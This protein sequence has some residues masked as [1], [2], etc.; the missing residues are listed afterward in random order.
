VERAAMTDIIGLTFISNNNVFA[1]DALSLGR[2]VNIQS[3]PIGAFSTPI[4]VGRFGDPDF[5][6]YVMSQDGTIRRF[7]GSSFTATSLGPV[8]A[9]FNVGQETQD[10][11][12]HAHDTL[13]VGTGTIS[14]GSGS[15]FALDDSSGNV[16]W[17]ISGLGSVP[18][19]AS[20][21]YSGNTPSRVI[22]CAAP[23]ILALEAASGLPVWSFFGSGQGQIVHGQVVY[24]ANY[25]DSSLCA[26]SVA[27][28]SL[29][30][31]YVNPVVGANFNTPATH[32]SVVYATSVA[33]TAVALDALTGNVIWQTNVPNNP[34]VPVVYPADQ[35][36]V[37]FE[38]GKYSA[39]SSFLH[40]LDASS[41]SA[42]WTSAIPVAGPGLG[43]TD[44]IWT[45]NN[46]IQ[47]GTTDG[48]LVSVDAYYGDA[49]S[50][51][52]RLVNS[53]SDLSQFITRPRW[54]T[55]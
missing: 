18:F 32:G 9:T 54:V 48:R 19:P 8:T 15:V 22:V 34:G 10:S 17:S 33:S 31:E 43:G 11:L 23:Q 45:I 14:T 27:D 2:V 5:R 20:I 52:V 51:S 53:G 36:T 44:P 38:I 21:A 41:G 55:Y 24:Y 29:L 1:V 3:D 49:N 16:R 28:G 40:G 7:T 42:L 4:S 39:G 26:R 6:I 37:V 50:G 12:T 47:I 35:T 25:H 46:Q 30:W 13:Y